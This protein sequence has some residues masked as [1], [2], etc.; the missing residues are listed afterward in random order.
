MTRPNEPYT[1]GYV[2]VASSWRNDR[3]PAVVEAL[4]AAG[5]GVYDF[6]NPDG[7]TGFHWSEVGLQRE[8]DAADVTEYLTALDHPRSVAGYES[9]FDAMERADLFVLVLPCGRSAHLELGWAVGAGKRTAILLEDPCTPE[10]MYRM[11]DH[12]APTLDDLLAWAAPPALTAADFELRY[13]EQHTFPFYETEAAEIYGYGHQDTAEFSAAV[14][15]YWALANG[16]DLGQDGCTAGDVEHRWAVT[17]TDTPDGQAFQWGGVT[18][19]TPG[20]FPITRLAL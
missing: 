3:Q 5:F 2:Y 11:V 8:N 15:R 17:I 12:L 18:Q 6:K 13:D 20:A 10:L 1:R 14:N 7:G 16:E 19:H 9:D 4:R